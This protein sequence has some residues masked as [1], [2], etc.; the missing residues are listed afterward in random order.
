MNSDEL[1][2]IR[3]EGEGYLIEFK[4]SVSDS[5]AKEIVAFANSSGG[6]I[7]IGISDDNTVKGINVTNTLKSRIHTIARN[8]D[9]SISIDLSPWKDILIVKVREGTDKPYS[10]KEGFYIRVGPNSQKLKRDEIIDYFSHE[11]KIRFD[12]QFC[13]TFTYPEDFSDDRFQ[14]FLQRCGITSNLPTDQILTNLGLGVRQNGQL[15]MKNAG[16]LLFAKDPPRFHFHAV[17]TC[18]RFRGRGKTYIIDRKDFSDDIISNLENAM[19]WLM[20]YIPLRYE[21]GGGKLQREEIPEIPYDVLREA[22]LNSVIHRDYFEKGAVTM[23]EY[24]DDRIHITNPGGLVKGIPPEEF[25]I[26]SISRNPLIQGLFHRA[27]LVEKIG[28]GIG[29]MRSSMKEHG[30]VEPEISW[31]GFFRTTLKRPAGPEDRMK[32]GKYPSSDDLNVLRIKKILELIEAGK[33]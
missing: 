32:K 33:I 23:V 7:F 26:T 31:N 11:G 13:M 3:S 2:L 29:R 8:C 17:V 4:E 10:C 22:I 20:T 1:D 30:L 9:P 12:E 27:N 14:H 5:L 18:V 6:R 28:S 25:G 24:F 15:L 16:V 21:I 19:K